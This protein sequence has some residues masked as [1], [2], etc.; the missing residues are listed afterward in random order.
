M[1]E[2]LETLKRLPDDTTLYPGHLYSPEGHDSMEGQKRTNP[3][4]RAA[5]VEVF[6]SFMGH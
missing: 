5:S 4:L 3:Y 2:S 1:Y 6:L